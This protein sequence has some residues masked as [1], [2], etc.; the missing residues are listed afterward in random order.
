[1]MADALKA[2]TPTLRE[3]AAWCG[4][5]YATIRAYRTRARH[6]TRATAT[7][8]AAALRRHARRL[9]AVA[10]RLERQAQRGGAR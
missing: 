10:D 2:A 9:L 3:C 1:M 8:F 5:S 4:V 7:R 6:P